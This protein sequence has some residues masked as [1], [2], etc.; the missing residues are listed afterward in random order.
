MV[1]LK[2]TP[3]EKP[4][5]PKFDWQEFKANWGK[6][7]IT[8]LVSGIV[9]MVLV[10]LIYFVRYG[11]L[12]YWAF[13]KS[14]ALFM[15]AVGMITIACKQYIFGFI[16]LGFVLIG[17]IT[18][19]IVT[20]VIG[21]YSMIGGYVNLAILFVGFAIAITLQLVVRHKRLKRA[22][23]VAAIEAKPRKNKK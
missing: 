22:R 10:F 15:M 9:F 8:G 6:S 7:I 2:R 13:F 1:K 4:E 14:Y 11:E 3:I 12:P 21:T 16:Y 19:C 20:Y 23:P 18:N 17:F 5:P